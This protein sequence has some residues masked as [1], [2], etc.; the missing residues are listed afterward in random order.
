MSTWIIVIVIGIGLLFFFL[1]SKASQRGDLFLIKKIRNQP[2][3][4]YEWAKSKPN[5]CKII[6]NSGMH[7]D[8]NTDIFVGPYKVNVPSLGHEEIKLYVRRDSVQT[9][10]EDLKKQVS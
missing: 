8:F 3:V 9:A 5:I 10:V 4:V 6:D 7:L 2:Q 1:R